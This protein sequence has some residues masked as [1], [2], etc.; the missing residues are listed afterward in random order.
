MESFSERTE[1]FK[2]NERLNGLLN[3]LR[4]LLLPVQKSV[5]D[6]YA[7]TSNTPPTLLIVGNP[8]TG[9]TALL[10]FLASS[11]AFAYPT[12]FLNRLAYA[13]YIGAMIQEIV[14][15]PELD[16]HDE[17]SDLRSSVNFASDLGKSRGALATNEF[18]HF[19]RTYM[20]NFV[21]EHLPEH[22]LAQVDFQGMRNAFNSL[23][24]AF[25][26]PFTTKGTMIQYHL[27]QY[28]RE[29]PNTIVIHL[30]REPLSVMRSILQARKRY[31]GDENKWWSVKPPQ[32][33]ELQNK[34]VYQQI[35][36]QVF[37]TDRSISASFEHIHESNKM[38]VSY[39]SMCQY[40][41]GILENIEAKY[42]DLGHKLK[43][44]DCSAEMLVPI[45]KD[46]T[47]DDDE[48]LLEA[49]NKLE[50]KFQ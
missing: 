35:A 18:H 12:N 29:V 39:E 33:A 11:G 8:R 40:P 47:N 13:P 25:G 6:E 30:T 3:E 17:F 19:F 23:Y 48:R 38:S 50:E 34:N 20:P 32:F 46:S 36:G 37:F 31:F 49:Y 16:F 22:D 21:P 41:Q 43:M 24:K 10:Q 26:K 42:R 27:D 9:S 44:E 15:N 7:D 4:T 1:E 28:I 2:P 5:N 45:R 14:F